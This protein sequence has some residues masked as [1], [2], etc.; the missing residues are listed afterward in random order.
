MVVVDR[1]LIYPLEIIIDVEYMLG[2]VV[3]NSTLNKYHKKFIEK[4]N[5]YIHHSGKCKFQLLDF[6]FN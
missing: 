3:Q 5:N 4:C 1:S 6:F 2:A